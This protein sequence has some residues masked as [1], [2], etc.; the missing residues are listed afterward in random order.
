MRG[1]RHGWYF[2][3]GVIASS[4]LGRGTAFVIGGVTALFY[5]SEICNRFLK[6]RVKANAVFVATLAALLA[7]LAWY[8]EAGQFKAMQLLPFYHD[9]EALLWAIIV[10][11]SLSQ[12]IFLKG[13]ILN[14]PMRMTGKISYALYL[15]HVPVLF[16]ILHPVIAKVPA[17]LSQIETWARIAGSAALSFLLATIAYHAIELPFLRL[18]GKLPVRKGNRTKSQTSQ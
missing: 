13:G 5:R 16:Y 15:V 18:K 8:G 2:K 12:T 14:L 6:D 3:H 9:L 10:V 11:A 4:F 1:S 17:D 7:I